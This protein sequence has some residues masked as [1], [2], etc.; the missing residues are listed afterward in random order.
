M[1][2][3]KI[4][5]G[6]DPIFSTLPPEINKVLLNKFEDLIDTDFR[7][8]LKFDPLEIP[9]GIPLLDSVNPIK[10]DENLIFTPISQEVQDEILP[11]IPKNTR[12]FDKL[13]NTQDPVEIEDEF[14]DAEEDAQ[15]RNLDTTPVKQIG[16]AHV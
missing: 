13:Q 14:L 9:D 12:I 8:I 1:D 11:E 4:Y 15:D 16:R 2:D 6:V 10:P 7:T 3:L 5:K